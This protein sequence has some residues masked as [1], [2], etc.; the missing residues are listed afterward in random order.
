MATLL[1]LALL[2]SPPGGVVLSPLPDRHDAS[3]DLTVTYTAEGAQSLDLEPSQDFVVISRSEST[4]LTMLNG[5]SSRRRTITLHLRARRTRARLALPVAVGATAEGVALRSPKATLNVFGTVVAAPKERKADEPPGAAACSAG[6]NPGTPPRGV[7]DRPSARASGPAWL[8]W[9]APS[10]LI[11]GATTRVAL[12]LCVP[13]G[14][15]LGGL[16][17]LGPEVRGAVARSAI[18]R[19]D[20]PPSGP[21]GGPA[22]VVVWHESWN[23]WAPGTVETSGGSVRLTVGGEVRTLQ[24][25]ALRVGVLPL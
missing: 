19:H 10:L 21:N 8:E 24:I 9:H 18:E 16:E 2:A 15:V 22:P 25:P 4:Q 20:H 6:S 14:V 23:L 5:V 3:K 17:V 1:L 12:V 11:A 7:F 13:P